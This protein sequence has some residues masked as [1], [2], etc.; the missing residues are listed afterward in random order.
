M[1]CVCVWDRYL[2]G[3]MRICVALKQPSPRSDRMY[4]SPDQPFVWMAR[5]HI[6]FVFCQINLCVDCASRIGLAVA[7]RVFMLR[8]ANPM[9]GSCVL[10]RPSPGL[11]LEG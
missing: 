11:L 4:V 10:D 6:E 3:A 8:R 7:P 1:D 5:A 2:G 9:R